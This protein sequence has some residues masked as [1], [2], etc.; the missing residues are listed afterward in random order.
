MVTD[1]VKHGISLIRESD[2][3]DGIQIRRYFGKL[4]GYIVIIFR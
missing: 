2:Y 1:L 3:S 4:V